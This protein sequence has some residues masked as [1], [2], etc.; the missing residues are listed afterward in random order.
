MNIE[1]LAPALTAT[2]QLD[3]TLC[4]GEALRQVLDERGVGGAGA[5][6]VTA[7]TSSPARTPRTSVRLARGC[8][9]TAC[10]TEPSCS[11]NGR[12]A[13]AEAMTS[14]RLTNGPGQGRNH[15]TAYHLQQDDRHKRRE[16]EH[17][18]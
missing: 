8:T 14:R 1:Y 4:D 10:R 6:A 3:S 5:G 17:P 13:E 12:S 9:R 2:H 16:V 15:N 11:T 7:T 18:N